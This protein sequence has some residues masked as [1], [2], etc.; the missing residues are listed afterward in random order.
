[1]K[2]TTLIAACIAFVVPSVFAQAQN[3]AGF[4]LGANVEFT[5]TS[6][7]AAALGSDSGNSTG[8]GL[9]GQYSFAL[10]PQFVMGMGLTLNTGNHKTSDASSLLGE[11]YTKN[12]TSFDLIP[13]F[14]LSNS[15]LAFGKISALKAKLE[16]SAG[17]TSTSLS[18][19]GYGIGVRSLIDKN[20]FIQAGYDSN[21]YNDFT[22][23]ATTFKTTSTV[24]SLGAGYKF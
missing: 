20:M 5:K 19:I 18:G 16:D 6:T 22:I 17:T 15:L 10:A 21:K 3:F 12:N 4:S 14:A 8:L 24:F 23:G 9:Q 2:R 7:D 1:M 13:G 11:N